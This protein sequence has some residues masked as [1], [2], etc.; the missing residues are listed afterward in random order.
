[1]S[2]LIK[3]PVNQGGQNVNS[4]SPDT[5]PL[6]TVD[7][8]AQYFRLEPET[9]RKMAKEGKLPGFK[10]GK[11]WRFRHESIKEWILN[12]SADEDQA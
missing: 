3:H 10:V 9:V 2:E 8:V 5:Q 11:A 7:D 6:W 12:N 4:I 1:M